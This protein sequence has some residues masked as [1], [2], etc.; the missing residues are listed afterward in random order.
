MALGKGFE[1]QFTSKTAEST[2]CVMKGGP[3]IDFAFSGLE[4]AGP[5]D[6]EMLDFLVFVFM[7][8]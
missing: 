7:A 8:T 6:I 1:P 4:T 5:P 2:N 3:V